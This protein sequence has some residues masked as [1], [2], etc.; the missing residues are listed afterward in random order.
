M[1]DDICNIYINSLLRRMD[2]YD[3]RR[4]F[5]FLD[6]VKIVS[7]F[8]TLFFVESTKQPKQVPVGWKEFR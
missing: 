4:W 1:M 8:V 2:I 7:Q 5:P 3:E 6:G